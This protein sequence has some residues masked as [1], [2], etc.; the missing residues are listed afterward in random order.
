MKNIDVGLHQMWPPKEI[1]TYI[2]QRYVLD[3][4]EIARDSFEGMMVQERRL[5]PWYVVEAFMTINDDEVNSPAN[6]EWNHYLKVTMS[7]GGHQSSFE[8]YLFASW[9]RALSD[10]GVGINFVANAPSVARDYRYI[11]DIC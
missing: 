7:A 4:V 9:E 5:T 1:S 2:T 6:L 3:G 11:L 8:G 10:E